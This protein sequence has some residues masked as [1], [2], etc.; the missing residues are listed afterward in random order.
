MMHD[1]A[2]VSKAF[3][4]K[5]VSFRLRV[6]TPSMDPLYQEMTSLRIAWKTSA[7]DAHNLIVEHYRQRNASQDP[8]LASTKVGKPVFSPPERTSLEASR[9]FANSKN[10]RPL[11][12]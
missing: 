10:S 11:R 2:A 7:D 9:T 1:G 3:E 4:E 12:P 5:E 8:A 6:W